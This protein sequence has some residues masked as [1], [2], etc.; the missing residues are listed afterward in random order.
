MKKKI[1]AYDTFEGMTEP[2]SNDY[3]LSNNKKANILLKNDNKKQSNIWGI[4]SLEEVKKNILSNVK[5]IENIKFIKGPVE[6]TLDISSNLPVKI[7][8]LRLDTDWY[9]STKKELDVLYDKV[10]SGGI[11]I[12]DD[13]GHWA[14]S[15][16]AVD[17][18]FFNKYVWMHNVDYACRLIIKE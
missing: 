13:Y 12:I 14:G 10:A 3:D 17:E 18:F 16:K 9:S 15:K 2:D 5:N 11:I 6:K 8:L 1:F 7:S 4:C